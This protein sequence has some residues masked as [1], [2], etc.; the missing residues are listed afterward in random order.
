[1]ASSIGYTV[2]AELGQYLLD[3]G[4]D[5]PKA[6]GSL[7]FMH[8]WRKLPSLHLLETAAGAAAGVI[9]DIYRTFGDPTR[10]EVF[11]E[12]VELELNLQILATLQSRIGTNFDL[13][14]SGCSHADYRQDLGADTARTNGLRGD[15]SIVAVL[16]S[17]ADPAQS[18]AGWRDLTDLNSASAQ[19]SIGHGAAM[20]AIVKDLAPSSSVHALR[21]TDSGVVRIWDLMAAIDAAVF[22]V[23][24]HIVNMSLGLP[25]LRYACSRCGGGSNGNRSAVFGTRFD[26]LEAGSGVAG[27]PDPIFVA[28]V[29]N[30]GGTTGFHWPAA[31][32]NQNVVAVGAVTHGLSRSAFSNTGSSKTPY[33]LCPGG[34][35]DAQSNVIEWVGEGRDNNAPTYCAGTSPA[36][37]YASGML[38]L[39]REDL[40]NQRRTF[41]RR[42]ILDRVS[43]VAASDVTNETGRVRLIYT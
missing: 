11:V 7:P 1:M 20:L 6:L 17:G 8:P 5:V 4:V 3:R 14:A 39:H 35:T 33:Y 34:D 2:Q 12:H 31:F 42:G 25:T 21:V 32:D 24:A 30:D 18:L 38:A 23:G 27:A 37:A 19:D 40:E 10:P 16:D 29:G 28:A 22:D 41:D 9:R 13:T 26:R 15:R 43:N 36:T